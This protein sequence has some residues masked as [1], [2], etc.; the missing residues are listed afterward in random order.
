[1]RLLT[2][3]LIAIAPMLLVAQ[4]T[5][6]R[7]GYSYECRQTIEHQEFRISSFE[8]YTAQEKQLEYILKNCN[9]CCQDDDKVAS[10]EMDTLSKTTNKKKSWF[11]NFITSCSLFYQNILKTFD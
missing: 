8:R 6:D 7:R 9:C 3:S 5:D 4:Q 11:D 1:M 2:I 10:H